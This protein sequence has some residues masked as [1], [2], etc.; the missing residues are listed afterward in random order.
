MKYMITKKIPI[1]MNS[2]QPPGA[3]AAS[4]AIAFSIR[5]M[6]TGG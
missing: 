4:C 1:M 6:E 3:A 2:D 5:N